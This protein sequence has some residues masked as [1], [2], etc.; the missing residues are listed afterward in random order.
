MSHNLLQPSR[1][2]DTV[3]HGYGGTHYGLVISPHCC[4]E[5]NEEWRLCSLVTNSRRKAGTFKIKSFRSPRPEWITSIGVGEGVATSWETFTSVVQVSSSCTAMDI[6]VWG[7]GFSYYPAHKT[8]HFSGSLKYFDLCCFGSACLSTGLEQ[9][10]NEFLPTRFESS[11]SALIWGYDPHQ[12]DWSRPTDI[13]LHT[14]FPSFRLC[15]VYHFHLQMIPTTLPGS[16]V[17][18]WVHLDSIKKQTARNV[19]LTETELWWL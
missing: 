12:M 11:L 17:R 1:H 19:T 10:W 2:H 15:F 6:E 8:Y 5:A 9:M 18:F 14:S 16:R 3:R 13:P 4:S 7:T